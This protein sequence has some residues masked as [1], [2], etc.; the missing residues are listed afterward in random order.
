MQ[1]DFITY[2]VYPGITSLIYAST[3]GHSDV[4]RTLLEHGADVNA[5]DNIG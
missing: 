4:V 2:F 5:K 3:Y 1:F